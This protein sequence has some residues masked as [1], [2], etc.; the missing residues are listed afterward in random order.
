[1][2]K[3]IP[4]SKYK[5]F[6]LIPLPSLPYDFHIVL[7]NP[8]NN[9]QIQFI[10][11]WQGL[12]LPIIL[13]KYQQLWTLGQFTIMSQP[14]FLFTFFFKV[15]FIFL[16]FFLRSSSFFSFFLGRLYF[17]FFVEVVLIFLNF[18]WGRLHF[19]NIFFEVVLHF[20]FEVVFLV[21]SK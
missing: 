3:H 18:F 15:I 11:F 19:F 21:G 16:H 12:I 8:W 2:N 9:P 7:N 17:W 14:I 10:K 5:Y 13:T 1:M 6:F 20:F 4:S